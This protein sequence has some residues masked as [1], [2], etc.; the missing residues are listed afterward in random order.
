MQNKRRFSLARKP[1]NDAVGMAI[2]VA[3][4]HVLYCLVEL[5]TPSTNSIIKIE[6]KNYKKGEKKRKKKNCGKKESQKRVSWWYQEVVNSRPPALRESGTLWSRVARHGGF[7]DRREWRS[8]DSF[9][10]SPPQKTA[11][12][13]KKKKKNQPTLSS[14]LRHITR[15]VQAWLA[16]T[17]ITGAIAAVTFLTLSCFLGW[18]R[19]KKIEKGKGQKQA[20][21]HSNGLIT[22]NQYTLGSMAVSAKQPKRDTTAMTWPADSRWSRFSWCAPTSPKRACSDIQSQMNKREMPDQRKEGEKIRKKTTKRT[23]RKNPIE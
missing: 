7:D 3:L 13:K 1:A 15:D 16:R 10:P 8:I 21:S 4:A 9:L 6:N 18:R 20:N 14:P 2:P 23:L 22:S 12:A 17:I 5:Q 19:K 11:L